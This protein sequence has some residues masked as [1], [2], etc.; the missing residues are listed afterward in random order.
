MT[1]YYLE[2]YGKT[3]TFDKIVELDDEYATAEG[4][5]KG[6][7]KRALNAM[8]EKGEIS[9]W[10][11]EPASHEIYTDGWEATLEAVREHLELDTEGEA[12]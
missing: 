11:L 2:V 4:T 1:A 8:Q 5:D 9:D 7:L 3:E 6:Q 12:D 10:V